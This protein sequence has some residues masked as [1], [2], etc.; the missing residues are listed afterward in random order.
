MGWDYWTYL[1]QPEWFIAEVKKYLREVLDAQ[2]K[3]AKK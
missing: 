2:L 3:A 1:N